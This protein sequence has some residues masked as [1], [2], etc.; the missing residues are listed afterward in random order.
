MAQRLLLIVNPIAGTRRAARCLSDV[1]GL[2]NQNG[3]ECLT[4]VTSARGDGARIAAAH[5]GDVSLIVCA[6]GDGTLNEV[7]SGVLQ[8][9]ADTPIGYIPAGSTNDFA[10]SLRLSRDVMTAAKDILNGAP[11]AFD[12]GNFNGRC[13]CY[14]A[15][16]GAFT[17]ASYNT[18]QPSKNL[19]GH[20]AYILEGMKDLPNIKPIS[21]TAEADG[22]YYQG[23]FIFGAL[24]N[25]TSIAGL[26]SIPKERVDLHDGKLELTLVRAP[27]TAADLSKIAK[28]I[29]TQD[30]DPDVIHFQPATRVRLSVPAGLTWTLDG[31]YE[32][33]GQSIDIKSMRD[34]IRLMIREKAIG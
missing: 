25:S 21:L 13:F 4:F 32:P 31:E 14:V 30:F 20:L 9:G 27:Q 6:G 8:A 10:A 11:R 12:V 22:R 18:S 33:G 34:A 29:Q 19:L 17:A 16:F 2:F 1:I 24:T 23:D 7:V 15:S 5:A 26:V 3:Y 28:S